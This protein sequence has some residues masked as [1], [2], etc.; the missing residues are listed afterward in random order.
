MKPLGGDG[1]TDTEVLAALNNRQRNVTIRYNVLDKSETVIGVLGEGDYAGL[2]VT[3]GTLTTNLDSTVK[4][5][6]TM[7]VVDDG[8]LAWNEYR[9]QP[10]YILKVGDRNRVWNLGVFVPWFPGSTYTPTERTVSIDAGDKTTYL[11]AQFSSAGEFVV[12]ETTMDGNGFKAGVNIMD[13]VRRLCAAGGIPASQLDLPNID[14]LLPAD[15]TWDLGDKTLIGAINELLH[16]IH[17]YSLWFDGEGVG[18][19]SYIAD[20]MH[21]TPTWTYAEGDYSWVLPSITEEVLAERIANIVIVK[22]EDPQRSAFAVRAVNND[23]ASPVSIP[24]LGYIRTKTI[25]AGE[26]TDADVALQRARS[27]LAQAAYIYAKKIMTTLVNPLH[28]AFEIIQINVGDI[29]EFYR[30][31]NWSFA[32]SPDATMSH[33]VSKIVPLDDVAA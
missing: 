17:Y 14:N 31:H 10:Q 25:Q 12:G 28:E 24:T 16:G 15:V 20:E 27:E 32:L 18:H 3:S 7:E 23:P 2:L 8:S 33:E 9:I 11:L 1:L 29:N 6:L 30:E 26:T 4:G 22:V 21:T 13:A 5:N 19:T